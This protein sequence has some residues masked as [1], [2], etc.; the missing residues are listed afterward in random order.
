MNRIAM[1]VR[2]L[3]TALV[4]RTAVDEQR[5]LGEAKRQFGDLGAI[6]TPVNAATTLPQLSKALRGLAHATPL[7][8]PHI[9][10]QAIAYMRGHRISGLHPEDVA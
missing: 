3:W 4:Q 9:S 2:T 10:G 5:V 6:S 1:I 7:S 8:E